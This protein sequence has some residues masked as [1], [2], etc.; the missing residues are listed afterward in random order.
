[1]KCTWLQSFDERVKLD[2]QQKFQL[3]AS[4]IKADINV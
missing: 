4:E 1:M 3:F 2:Y